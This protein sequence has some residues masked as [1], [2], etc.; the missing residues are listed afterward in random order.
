MA[1][2]RAKKGYGE[3]TRRESNPYIMFAQ[4]ST[5]II[6]AKTAFAPFERVRT[7]SQVR[8]MMNTTSTSRPTGSTFGTLS[9][10]VS[11]QGMAALWR[12]N[13]ANIY[14]NLGLITLRVSIYDRIKN[15][16]MPYDQ[17]RYTGL[18]YYGR[19]F[20]SSL[21]TVGVTALFTYPLDL[22]HTRISSDL[23]KKGEQRLF[24]NTFDCFNRTGLDEGNKALY[25]GVEVAAVA[26][27]VR[28]MLTLPMLDTLR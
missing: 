17:S 18:E 21:M 25:K 9:K 12:G 14:K 10:I 1:A 5:S 11:E 19:F 23:T 16:Y 27:A 6:L 28:C 2:K 13:N 15:A 20:G 26:S 22:I 7:L 8:N 4:Y 3:L 24:S